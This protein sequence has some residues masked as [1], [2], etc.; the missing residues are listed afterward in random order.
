MS[1]PGPASRTVL[2]LAVAITAAAVISV[3]VIL[4]VYFGE[5]TPHPA[6]F[7]TALWGLP[8]GFFLMCG[9]VVLGLR[10]RRRLDAHAP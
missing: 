5:G 1:A 10:R 3:M 7:W 8:V 6:L 2:Y 9:Y 4:G